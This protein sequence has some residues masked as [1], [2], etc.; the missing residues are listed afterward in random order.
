MENR[1]AREQLSTKLLIIRKKVP[2]LVGRLTYVSC[3]TCCLLPAF[4]F[5]CCW[6]YSQETPTH[7]NDHGR[8][9]PTFAACL[10]FWSCLPLEVRKVF[11]LELAFPF[12][13]RMCVI[14]CSI[15]E[16]RR[17]KRENH[18]RSVRENK[19]RRLFVVR[20]S[21]RNPT[22]AEPN[23]E[24]RIEERVNV[25]RSSAQNSLGACSYVPR[26]TSRVPPDRNEDRGSEN[27]LPQKRCD[28]VSH[29]RRKPPCPSHDKIK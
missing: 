23:R 3:V 18:N 22:P 1:E 11:F 6:C 19:R 25:Q 26:L 24:G 17:L 12:M 16:R 27:R 21:R 29:S 14:E 7:L 28:V 4:C 10:M 9:R 5:C 20:A 15:P 2:K 8:I 13:F